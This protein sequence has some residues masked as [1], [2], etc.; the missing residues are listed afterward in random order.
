MNFI[1]KSYI[2]INY[3]RI[4]N[5]TLFPK[6]NYIRAFNSG[7]IT[8]YI[9]LFHIILSNLRGPLFYLREFSISHNLIAIAYCFFISQH[10]IKC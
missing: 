10:T 6:S 4:I 1:T 7:K 5:I 2:N 9:L 8:I 3:I